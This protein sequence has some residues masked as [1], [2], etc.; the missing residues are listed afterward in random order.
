[1]LLAAAYLRDSFSM[2]RRL[3]LNLQSLCLSLQIAGVIG[4]YCHE[5]HL[6]I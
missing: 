1:M 6:T 5:G 2:K 4:M 3:A